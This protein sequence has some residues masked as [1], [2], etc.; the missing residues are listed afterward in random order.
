MNQKTVSEWKRFDVFEN[1]SKINR[2]AVVGEELAD[3][4]P[5]AER[6]DSEIGRPV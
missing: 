6:E 2:A 1:V 3:E 5:E 4:V